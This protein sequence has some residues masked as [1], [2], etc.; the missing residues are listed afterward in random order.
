[1]FAQMLEKLRENAEAEQHVT[2]GR[3][4]TCMYNSFE[5]ALVLTPVKTGGVSSPR[6]EF[7]FFFFSVF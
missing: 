1:M 4:K 7:F 6:G 5:F 2:P 3:V